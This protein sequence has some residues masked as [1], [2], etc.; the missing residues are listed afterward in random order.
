MARK[1]TRWTRKKTKKPNV[2]ELLHRTFYDPKKPAGFAGYQQLRRQAGK[3]GIAPKD[4]RRWL[5]TQPGYTLHQPVRRRFE[6]RRVR[7]NGLDEQWQADLADVQKLADSND[8]VRYLLIV[9]DVLSRYAWVRPLPK[10]TGAEVARAF[11]DIFQ[12]GREPDRLQT[13]EGTEFLNSTLTKILKE[14]GIHHFVVYGDTKAQIVERFIR[15]LKGRMW[16]YFTAQNTHRYVERLDEFVQGYNA[17]YHRTIGRSPDSVTH[18]NAQEVWHRLYDEDASPKRP[19]RYRFQV[20][21]QVRLS[22]KAET[23]KKG[24]TPSW[25]EEIFVIAR[26]VPGRPPL[27]KI[28]EWDGD[29]IEGSFYEPELQ[30]VRVGDDDKFRIEAV[31]KRRQRRG[32]EPEVLVRWRGW[33]KKYDRWIPAQSVEA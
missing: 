17:A 6:R 28:R 4:V 18:D 16:R 14:R 31:L 9:I 32:Q 12:E 27:Y 23:F 20:G 33:P 22:V 30:R 7:V 5:Q 24:Y 21:D 11:Q 10:K 26:R 2:N 15:T 8:G 19:V 13:D 29:P 25:T 1:K 3:Q